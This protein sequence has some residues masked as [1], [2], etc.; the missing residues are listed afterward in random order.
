M[1]HATFALRVS[2]SAD[3]FQARQVARELATAVGFPRM[4]CT[5]FATITSE[6]ARN[7][8]V[9]VG[10]GDIRLDAP[11][12]VG[13]RIC[14]EDQGRG[15]PCPSK[16]FLP[17]HGLEAVRRGV[18]QLSIGAGPDGRGTRVVGTIWLPSVVPPRGVGAHPGLLA[19]VVPV[20]PC[21]TLG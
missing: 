5:I 17:G 3:V 6:L 19:L 2:S 15:I 8:L 10:E 9:H 21:V 13:V 20:V 16:V 4:Q 18:D 14:A 11:G 7:I 1:D 12:G